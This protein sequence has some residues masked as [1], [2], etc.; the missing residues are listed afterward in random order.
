MEDAAVAAIK[1]FARA[2]EEGLRMVWRWGDGDGG[3]VLDM[4]ATEIG[5]QRTRERPRAPKGYT[6]GVIPAALRTS[7]FE[8]DAYRCVTCGGHKDLCCDHIHPESKGGPTTLE[9][10]Q[11]MCRPCNSKKGV[12]A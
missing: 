12:R 11:T 1:E 9:N 2:N 8:R 3:G 7:V 10:L 6:K 4:L 5:V